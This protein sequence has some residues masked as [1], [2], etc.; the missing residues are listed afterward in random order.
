VL[1]DRT[2]GQFNPAALIELTICQRGLSGA[3]RNMVALQFAVEKSIRYF[4]QRTQCLKGQI[5]LIGP[6]VNCSEIRLHTRA[7]HRVMRL[8]IFGWPPSLCVA[9][10]AAKALPPVSGMVVT[11][12]S[13]IKLQAF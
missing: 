4:G 8:N 11:K 1:E 7:K 10:L 13:S 9:F 3:D 12:A 2:E 6:S 5:Q